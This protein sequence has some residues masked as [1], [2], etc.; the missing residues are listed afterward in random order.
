M[1]TKPI[2]VTFAGVPGSS[3][4]QIANYLSY[5]LFLPVFCNDNIRSEVKADIGELN[6]EEY[7]QR[8]AERLK[9]LFQS[10]KS[11]IYDASIDRR[12]DTLRQDVINAGY[13]VVIISLDLSKS[14]IQE[15]Y[16]SHDKPESLPFIDQYIGQHERFLKNYQKEVTLSI[17]DE[18]FAFRL[19][20]V[21]N[22]ISKI[23]YI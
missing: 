3:K 16:E 19:E 4:S 5:N 8:R 7:Q 20:R 21:K 2:F 14:K 22:A 11:F 15:L 18:T 12:W 17:D 1:N 6:E 23:K 9:K 10:Q 13:K